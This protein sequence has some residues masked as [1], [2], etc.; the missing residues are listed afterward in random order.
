[1]V[2]RSERTPPRGFPEAAD[3]KKSEP[4]RNKEGPER[5]S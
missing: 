2:T 4:W 3:E 1:M 5:G